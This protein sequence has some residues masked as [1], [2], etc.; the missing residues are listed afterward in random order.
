MVKF[1]SFI[2]NWYSFILKFL[3]GEAFQRQVETLRPTA[4]GQLGGF[5]HALV[6]VCVGFFCMCCKMGSFSMLHL[7]CLNGDSIM[8]HGHMV[9]TCVVMISVPATVVVSIIIVSFVATIIVSIVVSII[10][11]TVTRFALSLSNGGKMLSLSVSYFRCVYGSGIVVHG[12]VGGGISVSTSS[13]VCSKMGTFSCDYFGCVENNAIGSKGSVSVMSVDWGNGVVSST[14]FGMCCE[15]GS[16]SVLHLRCF[17]G[18]TIVDHGYMVSTPGSRTLVQMM[19]SMGGLSVSVEMINFSCNN[20]WGLKWT[21]LVAESCM[22]PMSSIVK[23]SMV[24]SRSGMYDSGS[25]TLWQICGSNL[26]TMMRVSGVMDGLE[27]SVSI[28]VTVST[29]GEAMG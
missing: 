27:D 16:F 29:T 6:V 22:C 15:M 11:M 24:Q 8:D 20:F 23:R 28:Y 21:T 25:W 19:E 1:G 10:V 4:Q 26:E 5:T 12:I 2:L 9:S 7:R 17:N 3:V 14:N 13:S 18:D